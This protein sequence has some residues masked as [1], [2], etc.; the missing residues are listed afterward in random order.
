MNKL[1]LNGVVSGPSN[2]GAAMSKCCHFFHVDCLHKYLNSERV[3]NH[4]KT[5]MKRM[6]GLDD[7]YMQCPF[8]KGLSNFAQPYFPLQ[9]YTNKPPP[10]SE[11]YK[12][13]E[14]YCTFLSKLRSSHIKIDPNVQKATTISDIIQEPFAFCEDI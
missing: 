1:D 2:S 6:V 8:C 3:Q 12:K 5:F 7:E 9:P 13:M 14:P 10:E 4:K 11:L